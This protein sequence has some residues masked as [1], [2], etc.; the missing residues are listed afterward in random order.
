MD[1][2]HAARSINLPPA[3]PRKT[4]ISTLP[5]PFWPLFTL[6]PANLKNF[7][8]L[9]DEPIKRP[10]EHRRNTHY[11]HRKPPSAPQ[12]WPC[13]RGPLTGSR[14][15][16]RRARKHRSQVQ[17]RG[18][19]LQMPLLPDAMALSSFVEKPALEYLEGRIRLRTFRRA[20][21]GPF[22]SRGPTQTSVPTAPQ[23]AGGSFHPRCG[24]RPVP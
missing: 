2:N 8:L 23:A 7:I 21:G 17:D 6:R 24:F 5:D 18:M 20:K 10:T 16:A 15:A 22:R 14:G 9:W 1:S 4:H 13:R 11:Q 3:T 19:K 12:E